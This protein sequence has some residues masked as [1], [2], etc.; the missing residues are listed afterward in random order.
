MTHDELTAIRLFA[1]TN[2][3]TAETFGVPALLQHVEALE[4]DYQP[5]VT[6]SKPQSR[7]WRRGTRS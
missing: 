4:S 6:S 2:P 7:R 1:E 3:L 5:S